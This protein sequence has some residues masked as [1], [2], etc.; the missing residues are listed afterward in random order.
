MSDIT[1]STTTIGTTWT[2]QTLPAFTAGTL[3]TLATCVDEVESKLKRG[4]TLS[5]SSTPTLT[6]VQNWL[7]RKKEEIA[8]AFGYS[9]TRRYVTA[10]L[11]ADQYR[12]SLPPDYAGGRVTLRDTSNDREIPVW[13]RGQFDKKFPDPSEESSDDVRLACIKNMELWL[14]PPP[15]TTD[16]LELEYPR[17][18]AETT[19]SDFS[20]LPELMRY[21]CCDGAIAEAFESLHMWEEADRYHMKF[22]RGLAKARRADNRKRW[23]GK[24][25]SGMNVFQEYY[26]RNYQPNA[27]R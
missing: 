12:Y 7:I 16:T 1:D 26:I 20:W 11:V 3:S 25:M 4:D 22:E 2:E 6:Q 19:A 8:E 14:V 17:S 10:T 18:G 24:R 15:A 21:R 13:L 23:Q 27:N 5:A 9:F